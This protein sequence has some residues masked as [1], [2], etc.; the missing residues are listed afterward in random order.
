[1]DKRLQSE[2]LLL[3]NI[4]GIHPW[5]KIVEK[6]GQTLPWDLKAHPSARNTALKQIPVEQISFTAIVL[7]F[8]RTLERSSVLFKKTLINISDTQVSVAKE[9][10]VPKSVLI[11]HSGTSW[12]FWSFCEINPAKFFYCCMFVTVHMVCE[13]RAK[14]G[15]ILLLSRWQ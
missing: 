6:K 10:S 3:Y 14:C 9:Q 5:I 13:L 8:P 1:M 4:T 11:L 15:I 7:R 2:S 12:C